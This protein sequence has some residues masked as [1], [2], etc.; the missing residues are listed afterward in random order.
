[1]EKQDEDETEYEEDEIESVGKEVRY[2]N[3]NEKLNFD[4]QM[5]NFLLNLKDTEGEYK[6]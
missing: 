3:R 6:F 4:H 1:M 5:F 2:F